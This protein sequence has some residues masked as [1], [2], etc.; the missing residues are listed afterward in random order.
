MYRIRVFEITVDSTA[1]SCHHFLP[2]SHYLSGLS[3]FVGNL[4]AVAAVCA[5]VTLINITFVRCIYDYL[6]YCSVYVQYG[7]SINVNS[8]IGTDMAWFAGSITT[9]CGHNYKHTCKY[10]HTGIY[11]SI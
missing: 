9:H 6:L 5:G 1:E 2:M 8:D 4:L 3:L 11:K 7:I 10:K